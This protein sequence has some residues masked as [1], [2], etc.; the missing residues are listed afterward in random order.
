MKSILTS[1]AFAFLLAASSASASPLTLTD[2]GGVDPLIA[3]GNLANAGEQTERQWIADMVGLPL[4]NIAYSKVPNSGGNNWQQL[5]GS[6]VLFAFNIGVGPEWFLVKTGN[7]AEYSDFLFSNDPANGW[8]TVDYTD[9]GF[10]SVIVG[11]IS[12]LG[13]AVDPPTGDVNELATTPVPEP[14]SLTLFGVGLSATAAAIR[15]RKKS[16]EASAQT[17]QRG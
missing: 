3:K 6:T 11:K 8:A 1:C 10:D 9:F 13:T 7:G 16:G 4:E 14:A 5:T 17:S 2:V 12:H 15:R